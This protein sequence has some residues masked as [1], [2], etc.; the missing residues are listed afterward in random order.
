LTVFFHGPEKAHKK[1]YAFLSLFFGR[2]A[3]YPHFRQFV[4]RGALRA[5]QR[6][7]IFTLRSRDSASGKRAI[8]KIPSIFQFY[9]QRGLPY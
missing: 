9:I 3:L 1:I 5:L 4:A 7:Q 6:M 8:V 2:S